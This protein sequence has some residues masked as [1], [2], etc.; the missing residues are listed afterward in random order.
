MKILLIYE[1]VPEE[2]KVYILTNVSVD[3]WQWMKLTH[4]NYINAQM[5]SKEVEVACDMLNNYI[6]GLDPA[7]PD[8]PVLLRGENFDYMI[9]SGFIL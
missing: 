6:E 7:A 9:H 3:D 1:L 8:D 2:T 5:P 4:H